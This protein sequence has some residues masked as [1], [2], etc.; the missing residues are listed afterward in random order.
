MTHGK[1]EASLPEGAE[2]EGTATYSQGEGSCL[3]S[4]ASLCRHPERECNI[5]GWVCGMFFRFGILCIN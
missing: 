4:A 5:C 3:T 2:P 1:E